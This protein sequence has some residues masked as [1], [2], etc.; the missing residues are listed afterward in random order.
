MELFLQKGVAGTAMEDIA[1]ACRTTRRSIASRFP[2]KQDLLLAAARQYGQ[3]VRT[4]L[5][6]IIGERAVAPIER[7]N[8]ALR[9][10]FGRA[11]N[12]RSRGVM[13]V[14]AAEAA[15]CPALAEQ[16]SSDETSWEQQ[17]ETLVAE[18]Q[19]NGGFANFESRDVASA[20]IATMLSYPCIISLL[21]AAQP[22]DDQA[23]LYFGRMWR[24]I[25]AMA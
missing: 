7:L 11:I 2:T 12:P 4:G 23:E 19:A 25:L 21:H 17:L 5:G 3:E 20:A 1:S 9:F 14:Y 16:L 10:I 13:M 15:S 18:A 8:R 22:R 6:A 24:L